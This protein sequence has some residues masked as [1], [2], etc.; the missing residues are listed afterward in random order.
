MGDA[1]LPPA[2]DLSF[3]LP[4]CASLRASVLIQV[5][6]SLSY[7]LQQSPLPLDALRRW[8]ATIAADSAAALSAR[9]RAPRPSLARRRIAMHLARL[10]ALLEGVRAV[11]RG[12]VIH[13]A[14]LVLGPTV[15]A[16][17]LALHV[18]F[19]DAVGGTFDVPPV[20]RDVTR[21]DFSDEHV[22]PTD[23]RFFASSSAAPALDGE[24]VSTAAALGADFF[25]P[26]SAAHESAVA[27]KVART[28]VTGVGVL[29]GGLRAPPPLPLHV[30]LRAT[31]ITSNSGGESP[32]ATQN[33]LPDAPPASVSGMPDGWMPRPSWSL[34]APRRATAAGRAPRRPRYTLARLHVAEGATAEQIGVESATREAHVSLADAPRNNVQEGSTWS[35]G[36]TLWYSW[37]RAPKGVRTTI[38]PT[39]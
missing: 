6:T 18:A 7:L 4:P 11:A 16:P 27:R 39:R 20:R 23:G 19:A 29:F 38:L 22:L 37:Q 35:G 2:V 24:R 9:G 13:G 31:P 25:T 8:S 15:F 17:R 1:G 30:L 3:A 33:V 36:A 12:A 26:L 10:E 14:V 32:I 28:L 5:I 21:A 34:R